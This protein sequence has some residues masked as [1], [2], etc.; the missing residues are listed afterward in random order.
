MPLYVS[1]LRLSPVNKLLLSDAFPITTHSERVALFFPRST[2]EK[3]NCRKSACHPMAVSSVSY[4]QSISSEDM[5]HPQGSNIMVSVKK[6]NKKNFPLFIPPTFIDQK[7]FSLQ[8]LWERERERESCCVVWR[9]Q[10]QCVVMVLLLLCCDTTQP[11][12]G[13]FWLLTT[14]PSQ[15]LIP[16]V[17][18]PDEYL[19]EYSILRT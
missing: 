18:P 9:M 19:V 3:M 6:Q 5:A 12:L 2:W 4:P 1:S 11:L 15:H 10:W 14:M 13:P 16:F 8:L 17:Q 7:G